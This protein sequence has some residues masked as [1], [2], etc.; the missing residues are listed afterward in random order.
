MWHCA[1]SNDHERKA[2]ESIQDMQ[3]AAT[4]QLKIFVKEDFRTAS[5][6]SKMTE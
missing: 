4:A 6:S 5:E 2:F 3:A 1:I